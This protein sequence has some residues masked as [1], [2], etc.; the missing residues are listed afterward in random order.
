MNWS[1]F[2]VRKKVTPSDV[3]FLNSFDYVVIG[4]GGL[5]LPDT[6]PNMVSCWQWAI[7][8]DLIE[9][10]TA[11]IYVM[12]IGYNLFHGQTCSM[13]NRHNNLSVPKRKNILK[14]NLETLI[15]KSEHFSMRHTGDCQKLREIVDKECGQNIQFELCPVIYYVKE[16]YL[17]SFKNSKIYHTFELKD[18]RPNRRYYNKTQKQFY[19]ELLEYIKVLISKGEKIAVMSH[20][21]SNS[22]ASYLKKNNINYKLLNNSVAN[23]QKIMENYSQVKKLYC[24][25]GHSQMIAYA[26]GVD[27]Y[28]LITHDKLEYFLKD[29]GFFTPDKYYFVNSD[30]GFRL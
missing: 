30:K 23:E 10:I 14:E 29:I 5:L 21:G 17:P 2:D 24:T 26:L 19:D 6:N 27:F 11:K 20:D 8:S 28:S 25:A 7:S 22:F 9:A 18:D 16:K 13:P 12:S 4:G 1:N 15:K 3:Q